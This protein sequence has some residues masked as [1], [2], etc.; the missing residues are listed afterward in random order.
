MRVHPPKHLPDEV[1]RIYTETVRY[2]H[3]AHIY[4]K[5]DNHSIEDYAHLVINIRTM[6][7]M[8][9]E[10]DKLDAHFRTL[11]NMTAKREATEKA[12]GLCNTERRKR[13]P[14]ETRIGRPPKNAGV[15]GDAATQRDWL[16]VLDGGK[17]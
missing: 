8:V 10:V 14:S 3:E 9:P 17:S 12:L 16:T 4:H 11:V 1:A 6:Q 5:S 2:L 15:I 7:I 13:D